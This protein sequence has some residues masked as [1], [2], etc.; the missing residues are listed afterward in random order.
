METDIKIVNTLSRHFLW[1][2]RPLT[3]FWR[4]RKGY[5]KK[6]EEHGLFTMGDIA[7]C[8]EGKA[9]EYYSKDLLYE[10]FGVNAEI[11]IDH[12]WAGSRA[13]SSTL[14]YTSRKTKAWAPARC[15][16][17][18]ILYFVPDRKKSGGACHRILDTEGEAF[19]E[20]N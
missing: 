20:K 7:R 10:L 11:H 1:S 15:C 3:D 17:A 9:G 6:L 12:A 4:V 5:A 2:H 14:R 19:T 8:L 13:P 16:N 18:P